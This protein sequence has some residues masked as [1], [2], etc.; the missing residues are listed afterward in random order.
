[1]T[2]APVDPYAG[3]PYEGSPDGWWTE[4]GGA[5]DVVSGVVFLPGPN[6]PPCM[7]DECDK[8]GGKKGRLPS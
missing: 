3:T 4:Y 1:V 2:S 8:C 5:L 6:H 7:K